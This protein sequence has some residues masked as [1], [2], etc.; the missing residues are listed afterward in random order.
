VRFLKEWGRLFLVGDAWVDRT[1]RWLALAFLLGIGVFLQQPLNVA[2]GTVKLT[3]P[4]GLALGT[5][6][7]LAW[8]LVSAG[9]ALGRAGTSAQ[10]PAYLKHLDNLQTFAEKARDSVKN[11]AVPINMSTALGRYFRSHYPSAAAKLDRWNRI[12][13]LP[14]QTSFWNAMRHEEKRLGLTNNGVAMLASLAEADVEFDQLAWSVENEAVV[15]RVRDTMWQVA[16]KPQGTV[17]DDIKREV[18]QHVPVLRALPEVVAYVDA[19]NQ[20]EEQRASLIDDL[21][22]IMVTHRLK[23]RCDGC[24]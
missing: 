3:P 23:G 11:V 9:L 8:L 24:R 20:R 16:S 7:A 1:L 6:L 13:E 12:D 5:P 18:R 4:V 17:F 21:E 19:K 14:K 22:T 15:V 10:T 2:V